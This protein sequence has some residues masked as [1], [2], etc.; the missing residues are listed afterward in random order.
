MVALSRCLT[1][2]AL[3]LAGAV[4]ARISRKH[5]AAASTKFIGAV[6]VV[7]YH[8][9]YEG[10]ASLGE[11]SSDEEQEWVVFVKLGTSDAQIQRMCKTS[12][13]G[14]NLVGHPTG[15]VPFI[16]MRGAEEDLEAIIHISGGAA[17]YA[18]PDGEAQLI[19]EIEEDV[20]AQAAT[21][22]LNRIGADS[23]GRTEA[24]A[25]IYMQD[26]GV[27]FSH[28]EFGT[29]TPP[30]DT[31]VRFSHQEFAT[32]APPTDTGVRFSHQEFGTP[33]PPTHP[34]P[35]NPTQRLHTR[36]ATKTHPNQPTRSICIYA[37]STFMSNL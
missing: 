34:T 35:R 4:G 5:D 33:A 22:G 29:P 1:S 32:P 11:V 2:A 28:Q 9:A 31:G 16:E 12:K 21:W 27:R 37:R 7:N 23:R 19:P 6:P 26:T 3:F 24:G 20:G 13:K 30:T 10:R 15:R 25:T 8:N 17:S 14:C 36:N 18:E